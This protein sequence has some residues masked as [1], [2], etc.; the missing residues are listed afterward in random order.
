MSELVKIYS[1]ILEIISEVVWTILELLKINAFRNATITLSATPI[2]RCHQRIGRL[3]RFT[4][5]KKYIN[6]A[7]NF[8]VG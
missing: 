7:P 8:L 1:E 2:L 6:A 4:F 3:F 5:I